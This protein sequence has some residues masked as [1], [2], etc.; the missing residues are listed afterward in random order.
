MLAF[1]KIKF[2][3]LLVKVILMTLEPSH[4]FLRRAELKGENTVD[5]VITLVMLHVYNLWI[6]KPFQKRSVDQIIEVVFINLN[7][8]RIFSVNF[9]TSSHTQKLRK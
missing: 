5:D 1:W 3:I 9:T 4:T 2:V 8:S 7:R 6:R